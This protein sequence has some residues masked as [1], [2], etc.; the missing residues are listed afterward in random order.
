MKVLN[1]TWSSGVLPIFS[2][3]P[4]VC[5]IGVFAVTDA[6]KQRCSLNLGMSA[7]RFQAA[8]S[9]LVLLRLHCSLLFPNKAPDMCDHAL[10]SDH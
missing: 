2:N 5:C 8:E 1:G 6:A 4:V 10:N 3:V 9:Y 7:Q